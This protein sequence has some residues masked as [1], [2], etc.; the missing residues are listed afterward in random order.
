MI[1]F[2]FFSNSIQKNYLDLIIRAHQVVD[3]IYDF[4]AQ[5]QLINYYIIMENLTIELEL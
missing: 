3:D 1:Y 2:G 5:R 4:F